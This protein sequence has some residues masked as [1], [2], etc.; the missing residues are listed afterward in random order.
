MG[1]KMTSEKDWQRELAVAT[2]LARKAGAAAMAFYGTDKKVLKAGGG[3]SPRP[4][5]PPTM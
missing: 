2:S 1:M 3:R 4:I 5:T